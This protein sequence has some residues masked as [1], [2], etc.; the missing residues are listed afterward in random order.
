MRIYALELGYPSFCPLHFLFLTLVSQIRTSG[1]RKR[2]QNTKNEA[3]IPPNLTTVYRCLQ[4]HS[5]V[6]I[7]SAFFAY[8]CRRVRVNFL[9]VSN[10]V[11]LSENKC[12]QR[13]K[14]GAMRS[15]TLSHLIMME[16][17]PRAHGVEPMSGFKLVFPC[18]FPCFPLGTKVTTMCRWT[19][20]ATKMVWFATFT[21]RGPVAASVLCISGSQDLAIHKNC[22]G[23]YIAN[24][25]HTHIIHYYPISRWSGFSDF[26]GRMSNVVQ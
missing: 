9:P 10:Q 24:V 22:H 2:S 16:G 19:L 8:M 1:C 25:R 18:F 23:F 26:Q 5:Y 11:G 14:V 4:N 20:I 3:N 13:S 15:R 6:S 21:R 12:G 7:A 17:R